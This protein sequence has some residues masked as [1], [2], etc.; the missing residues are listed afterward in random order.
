MENQT[1]IIM[2]KEEIIIQIMVDNSQIM[3]TITLIIEI[4]II[5]LQTMLHVIT[6]TKIQM[7]E[8]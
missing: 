5:I 3:E 8:T 4:Q 7:E 6:T 1:K 2:V